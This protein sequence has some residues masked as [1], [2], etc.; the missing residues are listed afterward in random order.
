MLAGHELTLLWLRLMLRFAFLIVLAGWLGTI[1]EA[2]NIR[3]HALDESTVE[4]RLRLSPKTNELRQT[5]IEQ[6]FSES[7]CPA[8]EMEKQPVKKQKYSNILC[9]IA[10][11]S[12]RT[13]LVT[14][15]YDKVPPGDGVVD[16]WTGTA[17]LADLHESLQGLPHRHR[18]VFISFCCEEG[19]LIGSQSFVNGLTKEDAAK[20]SAVVNVD[21]L[22]LSPTKLW[23][24][25]ADKHLSQ[26]LLAAA[27]TMN[28]PLS[29]VNV[30]NVGSADS[31]SFEKLK[32]PRMTLHSVTQPTLRV[33]HSPADRFDAIRMND[34][35]QSYKLI[36][37]FISL[38]DSTLDA[39]PVAPAPGK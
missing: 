17:L 1:L 29:A 27:Q 15:H 6:L 13:I 37:A 23:A 38:L 12:D 18:I 24:S 8:K 28:L 9:A 22:G 36:A 16:N 26:I 30:E 11:E 25:K 21:S 2:Q 7:G 32:I 33:L 5:G 19:G 20:I 34:Y 14:A 3:F 31:E 35:Y 4:K 39:A 10:G